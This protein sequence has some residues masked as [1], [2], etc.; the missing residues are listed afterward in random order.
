MKYKSQNLKLLIDTGASV[1][2]LFSKHR[3]FNVKTETANVKLNG[4]AGTIT[5]TK[6][7]KLI[8]YIAENSLSH[9]FLL[10]EGSD[11]SV[12]GIIGTD[13]LEKYQ[14]KIDYQNYEISLCIYEKIIKIPLESNRDNI[15]KLA[16]RSELIHYYKSNIQDDMLTLPE[17]IANGVFVAGMLVR[18]EKGLIPVRMLNTNETEVAVKNYIPKIVNAKDYN[19]C[20]FNEENSAS[21][22]RVIKLLDI[23]DN[24]HLNSEERESL[25]RICAKFADV[26]QMENDPLT[27]NNVYKQ[28]I[29]L[30][31]NAMPTYTKQYR[32][33]FSQKKEIHNQIDKMLKDDIIEP[34]RS[35]WASPL[36]VVPK[37]ADKDGR[38]RWRIVIDY[39]LLNK[40]LQDDKFPLPCITEILDSLSGAMYFSHLDLSQGYYQ[41][42]LE[43]ES[44]KYTAFNTDRGQYQMKRLPMGLKVSPASFSRA[45]TLAMSGLNYERCFIYLDDLIVFGNN[46]LQHNQNLVK[47]LQRLRKVNLK[48][49]PHKC[50]FLR[51]ELLYLGHMICE[52]GVL[53]DPEKTK[54]LENFPI[55]T[56][57]KSVKRFVAFAN[58]YR[59]F[60]PNFSKIAHPLNQL[61]RK[62]SVFLWTPECQEAFDTLKKALGKQPIL[63]YPNLSTENE[64]I[65]KTDASGKA[66]G[67]VLCNRNDKPVA[68]ASRALN[69][70][71]INYCT[72]EKE[73]L[74][75]VWAVKH[76]RPYLFGRKFTIQTDHRALVYLFG[77]T[78]PSSRLTKFR[79][80]LEEYDFTVKYIKGKENVTADAL[81]RIELSIN[82]LREMSN[83]VE[84]TIKVITR[85]R[86]KQEAQKLQKQAKSRN[87]NLKPQDRI[88]RPVVVEVLKQPKDAVELQILNPKKFDSFVKQQNGSTCSK[89]VLYDAENNVIFMKEVPKSMYKLR[90]SLKALQ[91][92]CSQHELPNLMIFKQK[93]EEWPFVLNM[94]Q[95]IASEIEDFNINISIVN[96]AETITDKETQQLILNDFHMLPTGGHAGVSRMYNNIRRY[97]YWPGIH[98]Q[99]KNFVK[100]CGDCQ[101]YKHSRPQTE[102]LEITTTATSAFE[103]IFLDLVGPLEEDQEGNRYILTLQC[104]LSK[105]IEAYPIVNKEAV[106]VARALVENFVLRYG[107]P[108]EIVTDQG[109]EFMAK[110]FKET[111]RVLE[112]KKICSTAYHHE[113][114]GSLENSHKHLGAYL[115]IQISKNENSWSHWLPFWCFAYN[116]S[117]HSSTKYTPFELVFGK[118]ARLISSVTHD[119]VD[120][121]YSFNNYP[122]E[123]KFRLQTAQ[124]EARDNLLHIKHAR[125]IDFDKN[126]TKLRKFKVGDMVLLKNE[127]GNKMDSLFNGPYKITRNVPPNVELEIKGNKKLVHANRIK[128]YHM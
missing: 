73:L 100:K 105:Y 83:Q 49:N 59:R 119:T 46:L 5:A 69:K 78:N 97:Y 121:L 114:L 28:T 91:K 94:L 125:K 30:K 38:K 27:V 40:Q 81:S 20:S 37:K 12:D 39:R 79:I 102:P 2:V 68:Y 117:V 10:I 42:E 72:T 47:V 110:V 67:A 57:G 80:I 113:T 75:V 74:A 55:P 51:K 70:A 25:D 108:S 52:H 3:F 71:E 13:F 86:A 122:Q 126:I 128:L 90:L 66:L 19:V 103:K 11:N 15:V 31:Q 104:D 95:Q 116:T 21:R 14:A 101:R 23:I 41:V 6:S 84:G 9:E 111:C 16:P 45:M 115:R 53:P 24:K 61:T 29:H 58:Y 44:R 33:P 43:K 32:L 109:K 99:V 87:E 112:I 65:L 85:A 64:F 92:L 120:P 26:F 106:T 36:L 88:D 96:Q 34:T 18:S 76:F 17:E 127:L 4:I 56:D 123:L 62:N 8:F 7:T 50:N 107:I 118:R 82:D 1:S 89:Q 124:L 63:E 98:V 22:E 35:P 54:T 48:L 60:I 77:M 93:N